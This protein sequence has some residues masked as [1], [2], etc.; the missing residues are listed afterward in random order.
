LINKMKD[1]YSN[2]HG[3]EYNDTGALEEYMKLKTA[4]DDK[5]KEFYDV[6]DITKAFSNDLSYNPELMKMA[7]HAGFEEYK[8]DNAILNLMKF[9]PMAE[10]VLLAPFFETGHDLYDYDKLRD[11]LKETWMESTEHLKGNMK[12]CLELSKDNAFNSVETIPGYVSLRQEIK[13]E[14]N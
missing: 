9:V 11:L 13:K 14:L 5:L 10:E 4:P 2:N 7:L 12:R 1:R 3:E 6:H 8:M